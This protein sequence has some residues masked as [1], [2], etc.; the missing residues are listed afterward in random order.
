[1]IQF[2]IPRKAVSWNVF[3]SCPHWTKRV[4]LKGEWHWETREAYR[5]S[6]D[7]DTMLILP[8]EIEIESHSKRPI[9]ADNCASG[10]FIIDTLKS[11]LG[12]DDNYINII[13]V[14]FKTFKSKVEFVRVKIYDNSRAD[15]N[16]KRDQERK[17]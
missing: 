13:S 14:K 4:Q 1:M 2:T 8:L 7:K 16:R 5:N 9:D 3:Y 10:K 15:Q 11:I 12:I 6:P 17:L